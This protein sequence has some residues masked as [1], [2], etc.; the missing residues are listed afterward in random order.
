MQ[1]YFPDII[2]YFVH[3][4]TIAEFLFKLYRFTSGLD[5]DKHMEQHV[6]QVVNVWMV[7]EQPLLQHLMSAKKRY[8]YFYD[9]KDF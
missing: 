3:G 9:S 2:Q 6:C 1:V 4:L 7:P 5:T 8:L